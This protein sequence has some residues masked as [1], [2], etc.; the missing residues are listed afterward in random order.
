MN[1]YIERYKK[2]EQFCLNE[3]RSVTPPLTLCLK[4]EPY[5]KQVIDTIVADFLDGV[6]TSASALIGNCFCATREASY[7]L[8]EAGIDNSLTIGNVAVNGKPRYTTTAATIRTEMQK[9]YVPSKPANAHAWLTLNTGQVVDLTVL[10]SY[11]H[12]SGLKVPPLEDAIYLSGHTRSEPVTHTPYLTGFA[13]HLHVV[14]HPF[15]HDGSFERYQ[16]WLEHVGVFR[17][18]I[19]HRRT[20]AE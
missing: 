15:A 18:K 9:G 1:D 20:E 14:S 8:F 16:T 5:G 13:Y 11:Y 17:R 6:V 2:T 7:A 3:Y 10:A 19:A 4:K 12:H